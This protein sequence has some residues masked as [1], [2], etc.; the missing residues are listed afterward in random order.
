MVATRQAELSQARLAELQALIDHQLARS[1]LQLQ[2]G[3]LLQ[4]RQL[5]FEVRKGG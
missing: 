4:A 5:A 1:D 2:T 3:E